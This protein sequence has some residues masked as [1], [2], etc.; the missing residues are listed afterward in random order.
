VKT[1]PNQQICLFSIPRETVQDI[2]S[3]LP[4]ASSVCL[5]LTC[6]HA[7]EIVGTWPWRDIKKEERWSPSKGELFN[8]LTRD[9]GT[10]IWDFCVRCNTLHPPLPPPR[11]HRRSKL[12]L[13]C[14]CQD[15]MID[16]LPQDDVHGYGPIFP[17]IISALERSQNHA[18]KNSSGQAI[19]LLSGDFTISKPRFTWRLVSLGRRIDGNLIFKHVHTFE[20]TS[21]QGLQVADLLALPICLC[22]HQSTTTMKPPQPSMHI[23]SVETNGPQLTHAI[24]SAFPPA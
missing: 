2:A 22:P 9:W 3:T 7:L 12:T 14:F 15:A 19:A 5:T 24:N 18:A 11:S 8:L 1:D 16:Y 6:K 21:Q 4:L 17:H 13:Y 10:D 23:E 20:P